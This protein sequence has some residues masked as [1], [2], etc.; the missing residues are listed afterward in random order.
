MNSDESKP[1]SDSSWSSD[2]GLQRVVQ[3][4]TVDRRPAATLVLGPAGGADVAGKAAA[5]GGTG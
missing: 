5:V 3:G 1:H 2:R 4:P